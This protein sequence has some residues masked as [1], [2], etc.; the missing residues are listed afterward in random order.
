MLAFAL[1]WCFWGGQGGYFYQN[2]DFAN[3]NGVL[4]DLVNY[5]WPVYYQS[6]S[7]GFGNH[8]E[9]FAL[10]YYICHWLLPALAGKAV[11]AVTGAAGAAWLAANFALFLWTSLGVFLVLCLLA[12]TLQ[13]QGWLAVLLVCGGFMAFSGLDIVGTAWI[14]RTSAFI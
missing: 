8:G 4:H 9:P 3:R 6:G 1:I 11:L 2:T 14:I 12:V 7:G 5:S 10:V 13:P